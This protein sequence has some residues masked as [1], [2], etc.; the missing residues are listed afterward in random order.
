MKDESKYEMPIGFSLSLGV[1]QEALN[2][3]STLDLDTKLKIKNYIQNNASSEEAL[4]KTQVAIDSL[5]H[6]HTNFLT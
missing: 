2:Y 4:G 6:N 3:F 5:S 1:N